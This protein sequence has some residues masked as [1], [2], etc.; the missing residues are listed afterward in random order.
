MWQV[1]QDTGVPEPF[2]A[3][4]PEC[5]P[6]IFGYVDPVGGSPWQEVQ[7]FVV[8]GFEEAKFVWQDAQLG[9]ADTG[10]VPVSEWQVEQLPKSIAVRCVG[11]RLGTLWFAAPGP[12]EW[13]VTIPT[14]AEKQL[15]AALSGGVRPW[16]TSWQTAQA[17]LWFP[18]LRW[19]AV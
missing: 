3:R 15:G 4:C 6:A 14:E 2:N 10:E 8:R 18:E 7:F 13:Q 17:T 1:L 5:V 12:S 19:E 16:V 11:S 9:A